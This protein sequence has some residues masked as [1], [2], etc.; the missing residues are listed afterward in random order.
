MTLVRPERFL[1][2]GATGFIGGALARRLARDGLAVRALVRRGAD[3]RSLAAAGVELA[4][5]DVRERAA[6]REAMR[7]CTHVVHLAATRAGSGTTTSMLHDVNVRGTANVA[8]AAQAEGI[9]RLVYGGSLGVHGFV[10]GALIDEESPIRPNTRYRRSKWLAEQLLRAAQARTELPVVMARIS[11]VVGPGASAWFPLAQRIAAGRMRL[12]GDGA[13]HIDLVAVDDLVEGLRLCA[14][15]A[16]AEGAC[17][18][19]GSAAPS[20]VGGFSASIA[21]ALG[22]PAPSSGP[23]AAPY[24]V[25]LRAAALAFRITGYDPRFVHAREVLVADKR[26][27][28][29]RARASLGY[30]PCASVDDAVRA[31][32]ARFVEE[33]R[34]PVAHPA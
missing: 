14:T 12:L 28:S 33:G 9:A 29:E 5:G 30:A 18:V 19:L 1:I 34:L 25:L 8:D 3:T 21:R 32:V 4:T 13:N 2:T 26:S 22:V 24:R 27:S 20:T 31:M 17:Y 11:T 6:V 7:G 15:V 23:P 10:S 16:G